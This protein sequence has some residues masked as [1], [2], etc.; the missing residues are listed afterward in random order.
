MLV[1]EVAP[2]SITRWMAALACSSL[3]KLDV[4]S[5][6]GLYLQGSLIKVVEASV[7]IVRMIL[8]LL[9]TPAIYVHC[10][11]RHQT[12]EVLLGIEILGNLRWIIDCRF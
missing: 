2:T 10:A 12:L 6:G 5:Q 4:L 8:T 9:M 1:T 11:L 3:E 7:F